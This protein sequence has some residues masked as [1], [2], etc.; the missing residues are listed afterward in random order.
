ML[1]LAAQTSHGA[2][3]A[4]SSPAK[5]PEPD[6]RLALGAAFV[7]G[8]ALHGSGHYVLGQRQTARWLLATEIVG[9][10]LVL[11]GMTT[12]FASGNSRNLA[13]LGEGAIV[14]GGVLLVGSFGADVYGVAATDQAASQLNRRVTPWYE[15]E[16]GYRY[17]AD[18][19]F[20]YAHFLVERVVL[21]MG[22]LRFEPS[23]WFDGAGHNVRYR[24][25][26]AYRF[27][28]TSPVEMSRYDEHLEL[29]FAGGHQRYVPEHFQR[30][31]GE[32]SLG[33]RFDFARLG[34][35]LRGSF[36]ELGAG[37]ARARLRYDLEGIAVPSEPDDL[38]LAT[39]AL[40][41]TLRGRAKPGSELR[42]YYD[43]RHDDYAGGFLLPGRVSG[44]FGKFGVDFLWFFSK[45]AGVRAQVEGSSA[46][47]AG[48]SL[49]FRDTL[50]SATAAS[51]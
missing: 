28:G 51:P 40:G 13:G 33:A 7:P 47:V 20:A 45:H 17:V 5:P 32:V 4:P 31:G 2:E 43:H 15:S 18:P 48:A 22:H 26:G 11:G 23:G 39:A 36:M 29:V 38:L 19:R 34:D 35:T 37:Y 41:V 42:V 8:A 46:I 27:I 9:V 21:R 25:E 12:L 30:S 16:L 14:L 24:V 49:L 44:V 10:G 3:A 6:R 1:A 50:A